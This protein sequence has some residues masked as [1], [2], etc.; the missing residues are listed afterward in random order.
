MGLRDQRLTLL[1]L[2]VRHRHRIQPRL[3]TRKAPPVEAQGAGVR[4]DG[5]ESRVHVPSHWAILGSVFWEVGQ[6]RNRD[7]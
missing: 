7:I 5:E 6:R 3:R 2:R 4:K 1:P